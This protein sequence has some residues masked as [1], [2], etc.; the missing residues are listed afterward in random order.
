[1][2]MKE[3]TKEYPRMLN[4][5]GRPSQVPATVSERNRNADAKAFS[6]VMAHIR[7]IDEA[8]R[9]VIMMQVENEPGSLGTDRDYSPEATKLF[10]GPVPAKL[11]SAL[12]KK[13][14]TW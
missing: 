1:V 10:N 12:K 11:V 8:Y 14:G 4:A 13:P 9:T 7:Q 6:A 2:W 5:G 3:N